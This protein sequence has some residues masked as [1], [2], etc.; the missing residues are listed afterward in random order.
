MNRRVEWFNSKDTIFPPYGTG[1]TFVGFV[2]DRVVHRIN[3]SIL[4]DVAI[5][6]DLPNINQTR[7][8]T[9]RKK[10]LHLLALQGFID[11]QSLLARG[12]AAIFNSKESTFS[13]YGSGKTFIG[14]IL[15][16]RLSTSVTT[17]ILEELADKL[18]WIKFTSSF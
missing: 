16:R 3:I 2:L 7:V 9:E 1:R 4:E 15:E 11:R 18:G 8:L 17:T 5:V 14:H 13:T 12:V 6:L 10:Q